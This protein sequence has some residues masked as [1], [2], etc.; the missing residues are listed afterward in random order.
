MNRVTIKTAQRQ[1]DEALRLQ[2]EDPGIPY[3]RAAFR[4]E[5]PERQLWKG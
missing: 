2:P 1:I 4:G 5:T 3:L